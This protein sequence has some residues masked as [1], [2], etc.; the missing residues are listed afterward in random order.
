MAFKR[1]IIALR[2][3][4]ICS[5]ILGKYR[6]LVDEIHHGDILYF[7]TPLVNNKKQQKAAFTQYT[8]LCAKS[9]LILPCAYVG[10]FPVFKHS[11]YNCTL[12]TITDGEFCRSND[13][14]G[15]KKETD[16]KVSRKRAGE[17][18]CKSK[19]SST[20]KNKC[21]FVLLFKP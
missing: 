7:P 1:R 8:V 13:I 10:F 3:L 15:G 9:L 6:V 4:F 19:K 16:K 17:T 14:T 20:K 12:D 11:A 5:Y 21:R 18:L 2:R